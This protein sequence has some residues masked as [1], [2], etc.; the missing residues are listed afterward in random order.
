MTR[1]D[2]LEKLENPLTNPVLT[3][4]NFDGV[5]K[6]HLILFNLVKEKARA[7]AGQSAV[8]TFE[9]HPIKVVKPGNGPLMI[10]P[11]Q[12]KIR[13]IDEAGIDVIFCISFTEAFASITAEDF[14]RN[15]LVDKIGIQELVVGYDYT[16]G[17]GRE[18]NIELL[19]A[20]GS[21][22]NFKVHVVDQIRI[23]DMLV[24]STAIRNFVREGNLKEA[25]KLLGRDYQ[26]C[27][28]VVKGKDRGGR[29]MGFPTAN[30]Q[31][32]DELIPKPGVYAVKVL[33]Q[34]RTLNGVTNIG[35]NPT[36]KDRRLSVETHILDFS[37]D[38]LG[39][40]IRVNFIERLRDEKTFASVEELAD[41]IGKDIARA[42]PLLEARP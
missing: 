26:I 15:I 24:S 10:T 19:K 1:I 23:D 41:Q 29:L 35:Y 13:L 16:F 30:L 21:R 27:G 38:L 8:L 40:A 14:V 25:R 32:I 2:D 22:F 11:T 7:I 17:H 34:N 36:F 18:G 4:G 12:Q 3:I 37:Q 39:K 42:R 33:I 6:G 5:H 9:P 28:A 20:M 31:P